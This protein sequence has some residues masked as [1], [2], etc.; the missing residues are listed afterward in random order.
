[1]MGP[2]FP[3]VGK[4]EFSWKKGLCQFFKYSNYLPSFKKLEKTND[5]V[6]TKMP[7]WR[8]D[9]QTE[10]ERQRTGAKN[11]GYLRSIWWT[12]ANSQKS[13]ANPTDICKC[14]DEEEMAY[15]NEEK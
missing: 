3:N 8:M 6:L 7:T 12:V 13:V 2:F 14:M 1:M 10:T 11:C 9:G 15:A 4:N 5:P